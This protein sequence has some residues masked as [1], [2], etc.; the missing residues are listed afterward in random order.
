[1][2]DLAH[3]K[4]LDWLDNI[5]ISRS[6]AN[7]FMKIAKELPNVD[8]SLHIGVNALYQIGQRCHIWKQSSISHSTT[9]ERFFISLKRP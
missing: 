9:L 2:D 8:S 7:R 1:M 5:G 3:G 6:Y 4:F